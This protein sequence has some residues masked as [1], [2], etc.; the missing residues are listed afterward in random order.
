MVVTWDDD[1]DGCGACGGTPGLLVV[2]WDNGY[3]DDDDRGVRVLVWL[4]NGRDG[5]NLPSLGCSYHTEGCF[6]FWRKPRYYHSV[7][8]SSGHVK[9][10]ES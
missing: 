10:M 7:S 9:R 2:I 8:L 6:V 4:S 3:C 5:S 1:V